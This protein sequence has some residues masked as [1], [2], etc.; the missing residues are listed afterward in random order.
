MIALAALVAHPAFVA[1][2]WWAPVEGTYETRTGA[3]SKVGLRIVRIDNEMFGASVVSAKR[4][5]SR[6]WATGVFDKGGMDLIVQS[7]EGPKCAVNLHFI[8]KAMRTA[9][10]T[11]VDCAV[12]NPALM[13][14]P[15]RLYKLHD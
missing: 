4:Q 8:G 9:D 1:A 5:E 3:Q 15:V 14:L 6:I 7:R 2:S 11:K 12:T 10:I 13:K